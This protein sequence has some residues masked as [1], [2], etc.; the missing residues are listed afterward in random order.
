MIIFSFDCAIKNLG[1][2]CIEINTHWREELDVLI[3]R[4]NDFYSQ[5]ISHADTLDAM[6]SIIHDAD[7][8]INSIIS[9]RYMNIFNLALDGKVKETKYTEIVK[10]LKYVM[11]CISRQLPTPDVVLIE[12]QMNVN[13]KARGISRY[14]EEYF[15]PVR[16]PEIDIKYV[17]GDYP[18]Q[19][20]DIDVSHDTQVYIVNPCLKNAYQCDPSQAGNYQTFI[21]KYNTNYAANKAHAVHNFE[22]FIWSRGLQASITNIGN[23][24]DDVSDAFMMAYAWCKKTNLF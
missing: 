21:E 11:H 12:Y 4:V 5:D 13:D 18:L 19:F 23:K 2:C 3:Q 10:R 17:M 22:Y 1:F 24:L 15:L 16:K 14:I 8:L 6:S 20:I 9:I 7:A